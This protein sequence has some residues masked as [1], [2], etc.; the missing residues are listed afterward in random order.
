MKQL[1]AGIQNT[2]SAISANPAPVDVVVK[3]QD[4]FQVVENAQ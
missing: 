3:L 2:P 1:D 4:T